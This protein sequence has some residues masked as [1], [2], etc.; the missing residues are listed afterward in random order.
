MAS[1]SRKRKVSRTMV[2]GPDDKVRRAR[3]YPYA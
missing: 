2:N 1:Q 3:V